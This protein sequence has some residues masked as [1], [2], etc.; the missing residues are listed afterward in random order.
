MSPTNEQIIEEAARRWMAETGPRRESVIDYVIDTVRE[1]WTPPPA[2]DPDLLA[3]RE[4]LMKREPDMRRQ[5][6]AYDADFW[7]NCL[8]AQ[9]FLAGARMAAEREQ[10]RA[11]ALEARLSD[12]VERV[13]DNSKKYVF[14]GINTHEMISAR[15]ARAKHRGEA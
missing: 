9:A 8:S 3:F 12:L 1:N 14:T 11:K 7:D 6:Y 5:S 13:T 4:W 10:E 2:V 15:A